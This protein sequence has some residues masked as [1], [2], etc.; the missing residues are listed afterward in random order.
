MAG[1]T[2]RRLFGA[3]FAVGAT[4]ATSDALLAQSTEEGWVTLL[5]GGKIAG[6]N[7]VGVTNWHQEGDAIAADDRTSETPAFLVTEGSYGDF[8]L[9]VEFWASDDANSGV[10]FRCAD[11]QSITDMSC[12]EANIFDQREDPSYGTGAIVRHAEVDPMPKAGGQWNTLE[13]RA[14]ARDITVR[15]NGAT[16]ATLRSGLFEEGPIALQHGTGTVKFRMVAIRPLGDE[17]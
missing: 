9:V 17:T 6:W 5:E 7:E 16:T 3:I 12:Y 13:I 10:F 2:A 15:L 4:V 14:E 11:P 1:M 8:E